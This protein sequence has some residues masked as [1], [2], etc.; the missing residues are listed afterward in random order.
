MLDVDEVSRLC[1]RKGGNEQI[2]NIHEAA[3]FHDGCF[4]LKSVVP[5]IWPL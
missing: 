3:C 2:L 1:V 4:V 5:P